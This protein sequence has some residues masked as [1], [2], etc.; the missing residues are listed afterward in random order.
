[1]LGQPPN[2]EPMGATSKEG[3]HSTSSDPSAATPSTPAPEAPITSAL[4]VEEDD[5]VLITRPGTRLQAYKPEFAGLMKSWSRLLNQAFIFDLQLRVSKH[6]LS[7]S[8]INNFQILND[9][10]GT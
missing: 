8:A 3:V 9:V 7:F 1:M 4:Q 5:V 2:P 6:V 10:L